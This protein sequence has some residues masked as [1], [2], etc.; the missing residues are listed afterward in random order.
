MIEI[1]LGRKGLV[2]LI[3]DEDANLASLSW[4]GHRGKGDYYY[5]C[6]REG[7]GDRERLWLH[8]EVM[9]NMTGQPLVDNELVDHKNRNKLDCRRSNLRLATRSQNEANKAKGSRGASRYKGVTRTKGGKW[10]AEMTVDKIRLYL[11]TYEDEKDAARA[12]NEAA[13]EHFGEYAHINDLY[14]DC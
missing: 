6:H 10:K 7:S 11:G 2:A 4:H 1:P 14:D 13:V 8:N 9:M 3:D 12:Y 5:A